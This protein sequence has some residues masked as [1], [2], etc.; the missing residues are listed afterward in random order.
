MLALLCSAFLL[1]QER[2]A[3]K[4]PDPAKIAETEAALE[5]AFRSHDQKALQAALEAAQSVP[6]PAIVKQVARGLADE[7]REVKLATLQALRW[8]DHRDALDVLHRALKDKDWAA[9]T[10]IAAAHLRA[11]GQHADASSIPY[12]SRDPFTPDDPFCL[13]ARIFGL[14]NIRTTASLEAVLEIL[15]VTAG[16]SQ[17][18]RV[19]VVMGDVRVALILLTGVDQGLAPE[20]W[21]RWWRENKKTFHMASEPP[22]LPKELRETWDGFWGLPRFYTREQRR[23]DRGKEP[24]RPKNP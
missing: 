22:L 19:A 8:I 1:L 20:L 3:E 9:N 12:L 23:E 13:R 10:E 7:R 5:A 6:A 2:E 21:E 18:R 14:A 24:E 16:G 4:G 17:G 15:G 11:I